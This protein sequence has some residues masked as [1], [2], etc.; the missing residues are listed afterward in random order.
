MKMTKQRP[1]KLCTLFNL[2]KIGNLIIHTFFMENEDEKGKQNYQGD[3]GTKDSRGEGSYNLNSD[4][5]QS[6]SL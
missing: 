6:G 5:K 4:T 3:S 1:F 2:H